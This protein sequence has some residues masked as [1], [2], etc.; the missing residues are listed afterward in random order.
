[1]TER[2][3]FGPGELYPFCPW[4]PR[5]GA[6]RRRGRPP[7]YY[8]RDGDPDRVVTKAE[9]SAREGRAV[10]AQAIDTLE[11][12][13]HRKPDL[14]PRPMYSAGR[15]LRDTYETCLIK[16]GVSAFDF[17]RDRVSGGAGRDQGISAL[18]SVEELN[19]AL[20]YVGGPELDSLLLSV[21]C[22]N[23]RMEDFERR[24]AWR[25]GGGQIALRIALYRLALHYGYIQEPR[26][27]RIAP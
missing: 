7:I 19:F 8:A 9:R 5:A 26:R 14:I 24:H 23:Q 15:R 16:A 25:T 6:R 20:D 17:T 18:D 13:Y 4:E 3:D 21:I 12:Y 10:R 22:Q 27:R 1:M 2:T 11:W